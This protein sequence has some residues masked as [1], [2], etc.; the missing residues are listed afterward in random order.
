MPT[1]FTV[2]LAAALAAVFLAAGLDRVDDAA[3]GFFYAI[4]CTHG[5][6]HGKD[7]YAAGMRARPEVDSVSVVAGPPAGAAQLEAALQ[8]LRTRFPGA[9]LERYLER[10]PEVAANVRIAAGAAVIGDVHLGEEVS[11]W[12]GCVLR[13]D[14][15]RIEIRERSN[16]QDGSV[17]HLGD[18]SG[19]FVAEE[20]VIGHRAVIHGCKI[21][22]GTLVG[23]QA[24]IL[25]DAVIGEGSVIG[26]C[27][28]VTAGTVIPPHSL[29]VG[30]P[31]RVVKTLTAE[32]EDFHRRLAGK[33][34]RLAHNYRVG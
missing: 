33:Y 34:V 5:K 27:A 21:G 15:N 30:V 8:A 12:Y 2:A 16:V 14:V 1:F 9:V 19:T 3:T 29:V 23:I 28:L 32:D 17:V 18:R 4:A 7:R 24:T 13:G 10:V 22:G 11:V 20:V 31:G 6:P 26:S 25:D